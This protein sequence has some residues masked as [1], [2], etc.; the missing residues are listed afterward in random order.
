LRTW[1]FK[2]LVSRY[3]LSLAPAAALHGTHRSLRE[4]QLFGRLDRTAHGRNGVPI[5]N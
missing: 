5:V 3:Q 2:Q 4:Y 1:C